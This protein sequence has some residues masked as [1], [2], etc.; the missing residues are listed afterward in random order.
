MVLAGSASAPA[1]LAPSDAILLVD[2][3]DI[4]ECSVFAAVVGI[5]VDL[6]LGDSA[7]VGGGGA[8]AHAYGCVSSVSPQSIFDASH[9][10]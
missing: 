5:V 7:V 3:A 1:S 10:G 2:G 8:T 4:V 6:S 9:C